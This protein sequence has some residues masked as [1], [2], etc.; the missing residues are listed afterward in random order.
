[1]SRNVPPPIEYGAVGRLGIV[2][3]TTLT[4]PVPSHAND[5]AR[6]FIDPETG[7]LTPEKYVK[8]QLA[9]EEKFFHPGKKTKFIEL[10]KQFYPN[11]SKVCKLVGVSSATFRQ[12]LM[13]DKKF[14]AD[15]AAVRD[16]RVDRVEES[17]F[18]H[19]ERPQ[20]FM[21]RM[22][23]LRAYR[24]ELY[25][26]KSTVTFEHKISAEESMRRHQNLAGAV[27]AEIVNVNAQ[28]LEAE[29]SEI[30]LPV[31]EAEINPIQSP[32][33]EPA[34]GSDGQMPRFG[35]SQGSGIPD[36]LLALEG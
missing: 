10:A 11:L 26:P 7:Y 30:Q 17:V 25:N 5:N 34:G 23:I 4:K 6:S 2:D 16:E 3:R 24:G 28:V 1:M 13:I 8:G 32:V 9:S 35:L 12:H 33:G 36:P 15:L 21:D 22:A 20:N 18:M 19:S 31:R 29:V 14:G 27:D